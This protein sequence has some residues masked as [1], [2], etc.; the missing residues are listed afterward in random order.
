MDFNDHDHPL[1]AEPRPLSCC[2]ECLREYTMTAMHFG[3]MGHTG[4]CSTTCA[5]LKNLSLLFTLDKAALL[6][7][8]TNGDTQATLHR[9]EDAVTQARHARR[10]RR[11]VSR[12]GS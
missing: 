4:C 1:L 8:L 12:A 2:D 6:P 9:L 5:I 11:S 10:L 3:T 7:L